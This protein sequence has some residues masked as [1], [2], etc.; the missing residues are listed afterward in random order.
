MRQQVKNVGDKVRVIDCYNAG[1]ESVR[2]ALEAMT[3]YA[4][5]YNCKRRVAVLG[6]MLELGDE[7]DSEHFRLGTEL[8]GY[9]IEI[10]CTLGKSAE[11]I[12][13][14]AIQSGFDRSCVFSFGTDTEAEIIEKSVE[15]RLLIGDIILYKA[16][17]GIGL[18]RLIPNGAE[19]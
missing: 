3:V 2:A 9:G 5:T 1:P 8:S 6:D 16:S 15:S 10:L 18:E 4:H 12:A 13:E 14:G 7:S 17:R 11:L 19:E